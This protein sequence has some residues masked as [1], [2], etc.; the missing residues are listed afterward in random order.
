MAPKEKPADK[1]A[2]P[3]RPPAY[4]KPRVR[5]YGRIQPRLAFSPPP[6]PQ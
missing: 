5:E 2:T 1:P 4:R 3:P 6:P